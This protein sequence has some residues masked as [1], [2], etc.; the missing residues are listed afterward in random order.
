MKSRFFR[1]HL[2][3]LLITVVTIGC[4][5]TVQ[6]YRIQAMSTPYDTITN[7]GKSPNSHKTHEQCEAE[8]RQIMAEFHWRQLPLV[9]IL[10][11]WE[12]AAGIFV[13][14]TVA[15]FAEYFARRNSKS[16]KNPLDRVNGEG[17]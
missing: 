4:L 1:F 11:P 9:G 7:P 3:T 8:E 2:S 6:Y 13:P 17:V 14:I 5:M 10:L 15:V 12:W 16:T